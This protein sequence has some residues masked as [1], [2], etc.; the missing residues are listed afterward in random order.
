MRLLCLP[1]IKLIILEINSINIEKRK[2][3][4]FIESHYREV[5]CLCVHVR[6]WLD[7]R[8]ITLHETWNAHSL[9]AERVFMEVTTP[10]ASWVLVM[11]RVA[12]VARKL[13]D[14]RTSSRNLETIFGFRSCDGN[15]FQIVS[16]SQCISL[17][18]HCFITR[19]EIDEAWN[20]PFKLRR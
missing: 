19:R 11:M 5:L 1:G 20:S 8:Q 15:T 18:I 2:N 14:G 16:K 7:N 4:A 6:L 17:N 13:K 12:P 3:Y 10:K 9:K